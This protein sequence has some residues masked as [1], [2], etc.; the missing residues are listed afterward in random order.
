MTSRC[1]QVFTLGA[2]AGG[3]VSALAA[4]A[5]KKK[6]FDAESCNIDKPTSN[7]SPPSNSDNGLLNEFLWGKKLLKERVEVQ[8]EKINFL[9]R[10]VVAFINGIHST[11]I[12]VKPGNN[13]PSIDA[14]KAH[15]MQAVKSSI[16]KNI[17]DDKAPPN[18]SITLSEMTN[19]ELQCLI[20]FLLYKGNLPKEM[21]EKHLYLLAMAA[22][23][24]DIAPLRKVCEHHLKES[25]STSNALDILE[26]SNTC[27]FKSLKDATLDFIAK[28]FKDIIYSKRYDDFTIDN[29]HLAVTI[30]RFR[31]L[32]S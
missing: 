25:L 20:E 1:Y 17:L 10:I 8:N 13:E 30:T 29:P 24:Y 12:E 4:V 21:V 14:H 19:E 3:G 15:L 16:L 6:R 31:A 28:N 32:R 9:G 11:D 5:I 7:S 22:D 23:E 26:I 18:E 2:A 27:S